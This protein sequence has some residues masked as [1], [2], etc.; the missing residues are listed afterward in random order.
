MV[1]G[2]LFEKNVARKGLALAIMIGFL[3]LLFYLT[4]M[5]LFVEENEEPG[6]RYSAHDRVYRFTLKSFD[7]DN[8][9]VLLRQFTHYVILSDLGERR[10]SFLG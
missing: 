8:S 10:I 3:L 7:Y 5:D 1:S 4:Y 6:L 9:L 2:F